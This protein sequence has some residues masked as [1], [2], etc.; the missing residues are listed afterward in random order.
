MLH[1]F[2]GLLLYTVHI[3]GQNCTFDDPVEPLCGY[4]MGYK[5]DNF[6]WTLNGGSTPTEDTG[7]DSDHSGNGQYIYASAVEDGGIE[8]G[9]GSR[10]RIVSPNITTFDKGKLLRFYSY[11]YGR[12]VGVLN[13]YILYDGIVKLPRSIWRRTGDRGPKWKLGE[14]ELP[15]HSVFRIVFESI[16]GKGKDGDIALDDITI[17]DLAWNCNFEKDTCSFHQYDGDDFDWTSNKGKTSTKGTGPPIDHTRETSRGMYMYIE[18]S[19]KEDYSKAILV[20]RPFTKNPERYCGLSFFYH[21]MGTAIGAL[22]LHL[23]YNN[24]TGFDHPVWSDN[25]SYGN[26]WIENIAYLNEVT[27]M[28]QVAFEGVRGV[29]HK[30]DIGLD[31][32]KLL[33]D[34]CSVY[35]NDIIEGNCTENPC[36]HDG[37]CIEMIGGIVCS[38]AFGHSGNLCEI[39]DMCAFEPCHNGATCLQVGPTGF[40]CHCS[41]EWT[42]ATCQKKILL[43]TTEVPTTVEQTTKLLTTKP[44]STEMQSHN[45]EMAKTT[46]DRSSYTASPTTPPIP[47]SPRLEI[48]TDVEEYFEVTSTPYLSTSELVTYTNHCLEFPCNH[49]DCVNE[50]SSYRCQCYTG[51]KGDECEQDINECSESLTP[52]GNNGTCANTDG[53]YKCTCDDGWMGENCEAKCEDSNYSCDYWAGTD[54]CDINPSYMLKYCQFSCGVC[55]PYECQDRHENCALWAS[56]GECQINPFYMLSFCHRSCG[57][58]LDDECSTHPCKNGGTCT[59]LEDDYSCTCQEGW[60]GINCHVPLNECDSNP[61]QNNGTCFDS[62]AYY[63]CACSDGYEGVNCENETDH[64]SNDPCL[65]GGICVDIGLD[66]KCKCSLGFYGK[67]CENDTNECL[68]N[69]C[70]NGGT[71]LDKPGSFQCKCPDEWTGETCIHDFDECRSNPCL[72]GGSCFH[73]IGRSFYLC[74]CVVGYEGNNCETDINEC[75]ISP[76]SAGSTCVDLLGRYQCQCQPGYTGSRCLIEIDECASNPCFNDATCLDDVGRYDCLCPPLYLGQNCEN[77]VNLCTN[78]P[79]LN[80]GVCNGLSNDILSLCECK[81]QWE[82]IYCEISKIIPTTIAPTTTPWITTVTELTTTKGRLTTEA[83]EAPESVSTSRPTTTLLTSTSKTETIKKK[84]TTPNI[85]TRKPTTPREATQRPIKQSTPVLL[86]LVPPTPALLTPVPPTP[87]TDNER[88]QTTDFRTKRM[89]TTENGTVPDR[90]NV[91]TNKSPEHTPMSLFVIVVIAAGTFMFTAIVMLIIVVKLCRRNPGGRYEQFPLDFTTG[92]FT[93]A[94]ESS[95]GSMS[96]QKFMDSEPTL[97]DASVFKENSAF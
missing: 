29:G 12:G 22:K 36:K 55:Q 60:G 35:P 20:S 52:C 45:P 56:I 26:N 30:G 85:L 68:S 72:N 95:G 42:G 59:D 78:S 82:G 63:Q 17:E 76:C 25:T 66:Y 10:A 19:N 28:F 71:C 51:W 73:G 70:F 27:G 15:K 5:N 41:S 24:N 6:A 97:N 86:T 46:P 48:T 39:A 18:T 65:N 57:V 93:W 74:R 33:G 9:R 1:V 96:Y 75:E 47:P 54:E 61:C 13:V 94:S 62:I 58:C 40:A 92:G 69:P 49:G 34:G 80:N 8:R 37:S 38:C 90:P 32:I 89:L 50:K 88:I 77:R 64:C 16:V 43:T 67:S 3:Y 23:L 79:C 84:A 21:M 31:D 91:D 2:I 7:P 4:T 81:P 14:V 87:T 53:S 83:T 44:V 11:M